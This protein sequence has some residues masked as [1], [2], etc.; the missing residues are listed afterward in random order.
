MNAI[1]LYRY[2]R[3]RRGM[4]PGSCITQAMREAYEASF[5]VL[6]STLTGTVLRPRSR[7]AETRRCLT[8]KAIIVP[9]H[10][11]KYCPS[12]G[13]VA[14]KK[15]AIERARRARGTKR[16]TL[17]P[18]VRCGDWLP[19]HCIGSRTRCDACRKADVAA[20]N[21]RNKRQA[22]ERRLRTYWQNKTRETRDRAVA[23][24]NARGHTVQRTPNEQR[25]AA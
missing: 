2:E 8:C 19:V 23:T 9:R 22:R 3:E 7:N 5:G 14:A 18:C 20:K 12:C 16:G 13:I 15:R 21:A 11:A 24:K 1:E 6:P 25:P 10:G 4:A 17:R